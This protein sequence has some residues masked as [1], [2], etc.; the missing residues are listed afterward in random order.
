MNT[1]AHARSS[2]ALSLSSLG[3]MHFSQGNLWLGLTGQILVWD[4]RRQ[5]LLKLM[6]AHSSNSRVLSIMDVSNER[7]AS[8]STNSFFFF[9]VCFFFHLV[10]VRVLV[11]VL[12]LVIVFFIEFSCFSYWLIFRVKNDTGSDGSVCVWDPATLELKQTVQAHTG[13]KQ[14]HHSIEGYSSLYPFCVSLMR[15]CLPSIPIISGGLLSITRSII[16]LEILLRRSY[17]PITVICLA[18][19]CR[20]FQYSTPMAWCF[21]LSRFPSHIFYYYLLFQAPLRRS[22]FSWALLACMSQVAP[23]AKWKYGTLTGP[24]CAALTV[25]IISSV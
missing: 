21:V 3:G 12:V 20:G 9:S 11:L 16:P 1:L 5:R 14:K 8:T 17:V 10:P 15:K 4:C 2:F 7:V 22:V 6:P 24:P 23:M 13:N 18:T 19:N 25:C